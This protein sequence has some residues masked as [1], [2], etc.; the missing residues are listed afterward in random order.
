MSSVL[1]IG[2]LCVAAVTSIAA[3]TAGLP[4]TIVEIR[5]DGFDYSQPVAINDRRQVVGY[6]VGEAGYPF[7]WQN[8]VTTRLPTP[9]GYLR[10][11]PE[12]INF[13]GDIAGIATL[14]D[15]FFSP[16]ARV[17]R[18]GPPIVL[19]MF[20]GGFI[21]QAVAINDWGLVAGLADVG[22]GTEATCSRHSGQR[23]SQSR[24]ASCS[25]VRM[26]GATGPCVEQW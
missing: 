11:L 25:A 8:G 26:V 21:S 3:T 9:P 20:P 18:R 19:G 2:V 12:D 16:R 24:A 4:Y 13:V 5:H 17:W 10:A 6:T 22:V 23:C 7:I 1:R 15:V 14:P